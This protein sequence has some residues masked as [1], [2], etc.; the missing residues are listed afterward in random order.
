MR[1]PQLA[2]TRMRAPWHAH[3][4][5][6][7]PNVAIRMQ[8][9]VADY[10]VLNK[11]DMLGEERLPEL[12]EIVKVV[13]PLCEVVSCSHGQVRASGS[14]VYFCASQCDTDAV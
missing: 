7:R 5:C 6:A 2:C 3:A 14:V 12:Q 4:A 1:T 9:E 13:N 8:V 10:V 11:V